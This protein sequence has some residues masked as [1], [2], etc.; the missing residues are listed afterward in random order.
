MLTTFPEKRAVDLRIHDEEKE[1]KHESIKKEAPNGMGNGTDR[2][3]SSQR[4]CLV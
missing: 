1:A 2:F 3:L 4:F